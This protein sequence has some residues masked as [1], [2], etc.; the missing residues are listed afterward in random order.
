MSDAPLLLN[1]GQS[2]YH[3]SLSAFQA[4][5]INYRKPPRPQK[6]LP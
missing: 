2:E 4:T 1:W 3:Q 5:A 6:M